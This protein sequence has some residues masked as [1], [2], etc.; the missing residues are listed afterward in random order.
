M[1]LREKSPETLDEAVQFASKWL[2]DKKNVDKVCSP[3]IQPQAFQQHQAFQQYREPEAEP[4][5][6]N[7]LRF[8]P[9]R[10]ENR[11]TQRTDRPTQAAPQRQNK[12]SSQGLVCFA[13]NKPGHTGN[14]CFELR[15]CKE[16]MAK[17]RQKLE[18]RNGKIERS[19]RPTSRNSK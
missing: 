8:K 3:T 15:R 1:R 5:E 18:E 9:R 12:P 11:R 4:M 7:Q 13:C 19:F 6:V 10:F 14:N 17:Y 16:I 2:Q